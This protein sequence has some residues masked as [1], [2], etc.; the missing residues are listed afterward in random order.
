MK[1]YSQITQQIKALTKNTV[2]LKK[3]EVHEMQYIDSLT[4]FFL[5]SNKTIFRFS[6]IFRVVRSPQNE[7]QPNF[8]AISTFC[9]INCNLLLLEFYMLNAAQLPEAGKDFADF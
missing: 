7:S 3:H 5:T 9:S 8:I 6:N 2:L 1:S 4:P